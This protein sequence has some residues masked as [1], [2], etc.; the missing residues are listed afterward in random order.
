MPLADSS[1][2]SMSDA[3]RRHDGL[4]KIGRCV[5]VAPSEP[6]FEPPKSQFVAR[7]PLSM[8]Y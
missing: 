5:N 3:D 4:T 6:P 8:T 7:Q 2:R 1:T